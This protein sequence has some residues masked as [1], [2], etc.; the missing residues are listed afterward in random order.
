MDDL[1]LRKHPTRKGDQEGAWYGE[2]W[3]TD[4]TSYLI[5]GEKSLVKLAEEMGDTE[6]GAR[7]KP[8][9]E[10]AVKAMLEYRWDEKA[11]TFMSDTIEKVP[12]ATISSWLPLFAGVPTPAM[13]K[14]MAEV[15]ASDAWQ[16]PLP[17]PTV[18]GTDSRWQSH[19]FWRGDSWPP[20]NYQIASGLADYGSTELAAKIVAAN[21]ENAIKNCL[22]EH[23]DS[24]SGKPLGVKDYCMATTIATMRLDGLTD[25]FTLELKNP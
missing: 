10:K 12:V 1:T 15:L 20:T 3:M 21:V 13:A 8:L 6:M 11:G 4:N 5:M 25:K 2:M 17:L 9:I 23:Y 16:T 22:N 19:R 18:D 14:R 24:L 7:K